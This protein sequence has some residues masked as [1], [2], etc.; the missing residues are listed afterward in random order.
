MRTVSF[1]ATKSLRMP[2]CIRC[3]VENTRGRGRGDR[4]VMEEAEAEA[5]AAKDGVVGVEAAQ[6]EQERQQ[7]GRDFDRGQGPGICNR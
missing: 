6:E 5:K 7:P 1:K 2:E 4:R 3:R